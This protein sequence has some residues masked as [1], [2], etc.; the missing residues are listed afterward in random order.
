ML[1]ALREITLTDNDVFETPE[2]KTEVEVAKRRSRF[3]FSMIGLPVGT[4]L[5]LEKDPS[6]TC[7]TLNDKNKVEFL[8]SET[9]LSDAAIQA[10]NSLGLSWTSAS[11]PWEWTY[12]GKRLDD[13][14][15]EI[16]D[17]AD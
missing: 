7:K 14:R 11:G 9:S 6:I 4:E 16:D 12:Q 15:R 2:E 1:A 10:I 17:R 13:L 5:L 8:G 3:M